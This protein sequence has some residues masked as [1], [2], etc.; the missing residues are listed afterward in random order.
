MTTELAERIQNTDMFELACKTNNNLIVK[1]SEDAE[2]IAELDAHFKKIAKNGHDPEHEI[3]AFIQETVNRTLD[4]APDELLDRI[5]DV[6]TIGADDDFE[7]VVD[8]KNTLIGYE[9]AQGG[10]V[11]RS[12]LDASVMA[13]TWK[14]RQ[15]DTEISFKDIERNGWKTVAKITEYAVRELANLKFKDVFTAI[16]NAITSGA[17]NYLAVGG[18]AVTDAAAQA[19]SIYVNDRAN[20]DSVFVGMRKYMSQISHLTGYTP[21]EAMREEIH[22]TGMLGMYEGTDLYPV[23]GVA[24][25]GNGEPLFLDKRVFA[26][27]GKIGK[28]NQKGEVKVYQETD[29][30]KDKFV[31]Y[32]KDYTYGWAFNDNA[33]ENVYKLVLQ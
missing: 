28:L 15:I 13:P 18:T 6:G 23:S 7:N 29:V 31:I 14:N 33:L 12:Y 19:A 2:V 26:V 4:E 10:V 25:L 20:G 11:P 17:A 1:D 16:D 27:A 3:A 9:A 8:P 5:F 22:L 30:Q 32:I 24:K 21:S